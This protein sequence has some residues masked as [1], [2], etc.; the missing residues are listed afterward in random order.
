MITVRKRTAIENMGAAFGG[1]SP[2]APQASAGEVE[3]LHAKFGQLVIERNFFCR[4]PP[5]SSSALK[6]KRGE[7]GSSRSQR[8]ATMQAAVSGAL[9]P[10]LPA[11]RRKR[12]EPEIHGDHRPAV[13]R[14]AMVW[15]GANGP[16]YATRGASMRAAS[17]PSADEADASGSDSSGAEDQQEAPGA[18][19]LSVS[20]EGL[21]HH[22]PQSGRV[23]RTSA[24]S[25]CAVGSCIWSR[26]W[27][28]TA[29]RC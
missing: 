6:A 24:T 11:A 3:E 10:L 17:G 12:R 28:G 7:T 21:D 1:A 4:Q 16:L 25:R 18:Q 23:A 13:S 22:P 8:S 19:D 20:S 15:V 5:V 27:T 26:S 2:M 29:A 9:R 14:D